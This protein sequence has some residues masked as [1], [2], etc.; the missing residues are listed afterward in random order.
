M[1]DS[2]RPSAKAVVSQRLFTPG[3]FDF[4]FNPVYLIRRPLFQR[5][6]TIAP[7]I[8][9]EILDF[10]CGSMPYRKLF[11]QSSSYVGLDLETSNH[12]LSQPDVVLD[13]TAIPFG[14][15][16][17]D[18]VVSFEVIDDLSE[19]LLQL[20]EM[21]RV[22]KSSGTLLLTTTFVWELHEEPHDIARYTQHGL[23]ELLEKAG[24]DVISVDRLGHY[25]TVIGQMIAM[26]WYQTLQKV[27]L[28]ILPGVAVAGI[29]QFLTLLVQHLIPKRRELWLSNVV[30]ARKK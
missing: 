9:G 30:I 15:N 19:P 8:T 22:L 23:R 27:P 11:S 2:G 28:G 25:T 21:A 6:K 1:S 16:R 14:D 7:T 12:G 20:S 18:A 24:F 3:V 29:V 26:Y 4:F 5:L 13:G 10:G 17:F